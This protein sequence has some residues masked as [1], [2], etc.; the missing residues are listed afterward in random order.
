MKWLLITVVTILAV[1]ST[2]CTQEQI[3]EEEL[4]E[5]ISSSTDEIDTYEF[6]MRAESST[7]LS[8]YGKKA[9]LETIT[10]G[11]GV[12]DRESKNMKL[13][14]TTT[15]GVSGRSSTVG[16]RAKL[17]CMNDSLYMKTSIGISETPSGWLKM[18]MTEEGWNTQNQLDEYFELLNKSEVEVKGSEKVNGTDCYAVK[19]IPHNETLWEMMVNE[20]AM[21]KQMQEINRNEMKIENTSAKYWV[22]KDTCFPVKTETRMQLKL[23]SEALNVTSQEDLTAE[24]NLAVKVSYHNYNEPVSI[25]LPQE[26]Q[27]AVSAPEQLKQLGNS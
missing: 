22:A 9:G 20:P 11:K 8:R 18:Q 24:M 6:G 4:K 1:L 10:T 2:G 25:S 17:Y 19:V 5:E 13:E 21:S 16:S 26:A 14:M 27:N 23:D 15:M 3:S 12:V 7:E